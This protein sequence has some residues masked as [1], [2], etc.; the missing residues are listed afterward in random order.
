M[1]KICCASSYKAG[2]YDVK[3]FEGY[4]CYLQSKEYCIMASGNIIEFSISVS[5]AEKL[6]LS[7]TYT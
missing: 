2:R 5:E 3:A 7:P 1:E 4:I 6:F